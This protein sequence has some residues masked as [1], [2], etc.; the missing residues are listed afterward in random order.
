MELDNLRDRRRKINEHA[1]STLSNME[2]ISE[3]SF[4]VAT[5]AKN[6]EIILDDLDEQFTKQ[7]GLNKVDISFLMVATALQIVKWI[8][9]DT[10]GDKIDKSKRVNEKSGDRIVKEEIKDYDDKHSNWKTER[11]KAGY[12]SWKEIIYSSV[13]YDAKR[14]S[15][16]RYSNGRYVS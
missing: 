2:K 14:G 16:I 11:S 7:T 15:C 13:P 4:R 12:K 10:I 6:A 1:K 8:M 5:V 3:E 9:M